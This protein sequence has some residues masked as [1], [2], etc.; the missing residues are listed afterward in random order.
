MRVANEIH[1]KYVD[2]LTLAEA[3]NL[4]K[5]VVSLADNERPQPNMF[6]ARNGHVLPLD[7]SKVHKQLVKT[8][9]YAK[10]NEM[11]INYKKTIVMLLTHAP[12]ST[13]CLK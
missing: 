3:I 9:E 7:N 13:L 2:D 5:N 11:Q 10:A 12:L 6:H 8:L 4:P 1:L